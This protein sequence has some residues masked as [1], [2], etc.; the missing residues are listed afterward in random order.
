MSKRRVSI[1]GFSFS[2]SGWN[3]CVFDLDLNFRKQLPNCYFETLWAG[4]RS[5]G[6]NAFAERPAQGTGE[7][8]HGFVRVPEIHC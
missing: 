7:T 5:Q 6:G 8:P 1:F 2:K 3:P 4:V